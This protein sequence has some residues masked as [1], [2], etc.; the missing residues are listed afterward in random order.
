MTTRLSNGKAAYLFTEPLAK[1]WFWET[2]LN[3]SQT[4]ND[5]DRQATDPDLNNTRVDSLSIFYNQNTRYQRLGSSLRY[6]Y[7]GLNATAG[8]AMQ[9]IVLSGDYARQKGQLLL[10]A[11]IKRTFNNLTPNVDMNYEFAPNTNLNFNY[12]YGITAPNLTDLQPVPNINNP[13]FRIEGNPDLAPERQHNVSMNL[14]KWNPANFSYFGVGTQYQIYESQIVYNQTIEQIDSIGI[15]TTTRPDNVSGGSNFNLYSWF[16]FPIIKT[17]LTFNGGPNA[18]FGQSS[19][20][21]NNVLNKTRNNGYGGNLGFNIT[22][23][24]KL[25]VDLSGRLQFNDLKYSIQQEQNQRIQ[26]HSLDAS[27]KWQFADKFF[28]ES[29]FN[30][31]FYRN[32]RFGFNRNVPIWNASVRRLLGK[33][34]RLEMRLA[35]FDLLNR[36]VNI[37]QTGTQN[38]VTRVISNTLAQYFMLSVSY[39]VRGYENKVKKNDWW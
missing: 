21:V 30:Y 36:Q 33:N 20:F 8:L 19:A 26:A 22:P 7:K 24:P 29:N 27:L 34:N 39:N 9:Q 5:V 31:S 25:I 14:N 37:V 3:F 13:A 23:T 32:D 38:Y 18:N 6:S 35:A 17:K 2:F 1:K 10:T 12:G 4:H 28:L 11:P 15:R 16:N